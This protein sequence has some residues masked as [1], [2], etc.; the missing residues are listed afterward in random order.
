[1]NLKCVLSLG[2]LIAGV[3][4]ATADKA[5]DLSGALGKPTVTDDFDRP[6]LGRQWQVAK[7]EWKIEDGAIVGR[8]LKSDQHA[9]VLS[10]QQ[11][12]HNSAIQFSFRLD[13]AKGFHLSFNKKRGHLFR[14]L[15]APTGLTATLDKDK[16]DPKSKPQRLGAAKGRFEQG[17]WYTM[18][19][20]VEG[21]KVTAQ[22]DN[23]VKLTARHADIDQPKPNYR[24][25]LRGGDLRLDD[26][27]IWRL[28]QP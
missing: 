25:V 1:M 7:G 12:N 3:T 5:S 26:L 22:T 18:L 2:L 15:V 6:Q 24:F 14:I 21:S 11:P 9:A 28:E 19:V 4:S 8:E 10:F 23:G 17:K 13:G 20:R 16:K 27:R